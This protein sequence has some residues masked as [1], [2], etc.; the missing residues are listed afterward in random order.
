MKGRSFHVRLSC[1]CAGLFAAWRRERSFRTQIYLAVGAIVV[2][3]VL[4]P[5]PVW[6]ALLALAIGLVLGMELLNTA[7]EKLVDH[8]H[9]AQHP[10]IKIVKDVAAAA[11]LIAS[12]AAVAIGVCLIIAAI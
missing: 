2:T 10:E 12:L 5:Q 9:P 4:K 8:L 6:W 1:A 3:A 7:I 11:V